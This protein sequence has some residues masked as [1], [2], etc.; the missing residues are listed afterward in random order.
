M[1]IKIY[2]AYRLRR[3]IDLFSLLWD[4]KREGQRQAQTR[5]K[6]IFETV[7][8]GRSHTAYLKLQEQENLFRAWAH[9]E[10]GKDPGTDV[11]L[12]LYAKWLRDECP[13][14][15]RVE[16]NT[17]SVS[18][19]EVLAMA[20]RDATE[21][22]RPGVFDVDAWA[23][24]K[25]G[26]QRNQYDRNLWALDVCVTTRRCRDRFYLIPYCDHMCLLRGCL[27]FMRD[28]ERLEDFSYWNNTDKPE[29][30]TSQ[31]WTW[32]GTVWNELTKPERWSEFVVL[33]VVS[34][35]GWSQVSPM[36]GLLREQYEEASR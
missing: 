31:A 6:R 10:H 17:L 13:P 32:R 9:D 29:E 24:A 36:M 3:G 33:D 25:Y 18:D 2:E 14:E 20:K 26:E 15:F 27:D 28:D 19:Q 21:G 12:G 34:W 16:E 4:V 30:V 5:L 7:L 8:D 22:M 35:E 1:S 23:L 11:T